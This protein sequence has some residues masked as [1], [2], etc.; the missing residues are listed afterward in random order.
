MTAMGTHCWGC[1][2]ACHC[3]L[4]SRPTPALTPGGLLQLVIQI[5]KSKG[6]SSINIV[7]GRSEAAMQAVEQ[8][9][10]GLGADVV[11]TEEKLREA[12]GEQSGARLPGEGMG[13][14]AVA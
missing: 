6:V 7:R 10:K 4:S 3:S 1:Q 11:T 9:L 13:A 2:H 12:V 14:R 5:A 8:H